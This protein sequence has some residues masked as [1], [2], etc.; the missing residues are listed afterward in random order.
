MPFKQIQHLHFVLIKLRHH[1]AYWARYAKA[2]RFLKVN[3]FNSRRF[4]C[5]QLI[6][7]IPLLSN[8]VDKFS[9][10]QVLCQWLI[11]IIILLI[12]GMRLMCDRFRLVM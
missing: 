8:D 5:F 12:F 3:L 9:I 1:G 6:F 11:Y 10:Y 7:H 2:K 4:V